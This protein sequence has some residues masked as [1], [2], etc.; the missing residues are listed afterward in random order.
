MSINNP[1]TKCYLAQ[2]LTR[3]GYENLGLYL[4]FRELLDAELKLDIPVERVLMLPFVQPQTTDNSCSALDE[5]EAYVQFAL[6]NF[7]DYPDVAPEAAGGLC[8]A[9]HP[10]ECYEIADQEANDQHR[11][12]LEQLDHERQERDNLNPFT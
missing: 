5:T 4:S 7:R 11:A 1:L 6:Q 10:N 8:F 9:I 3:R 2:N 12:Y